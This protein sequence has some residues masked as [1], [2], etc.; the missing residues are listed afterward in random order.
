MVRPGPS[1]WLI[2]AALFAVYVIWGSTYVAMAVGVDHFPPFMLGGLR[3]TAAGLLIFAFI[4]WRGEALPT[5]A[6]W[7]SGLITGFF[8]LMIGNGAVNFAVM[9]V[10]SGLAAL[11]VA[12]SSLFAALF[13]RMLG[14]PVSRREWLGIAVGFAGVALLAS[15]GELR[16]DTFGALLLIVAS[17]SW[18][19]GSMWSKRLPQPP[20]VWMAS[21]T[22]LIC[23]GIGMLLVSLLRGEEFPAA[24]PPVAWFALVYLAIFGAIIAFS[25]YAFLLKHTRPAL[26]TSTAYVNPVIAVV[27]GGWLLDE[28]VT[29]R[30]WLAM[31]IVL[32]GVVLV[33]TGGSAR[34]GTQKPRA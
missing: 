30:E 33:T 24:P 2:A 1:P 14:D 17:A 9:T 8:L 6:Q 29:A 21:A 10:S 23:G 34:S 28:V 18:A 16:S 3:Y 22:Q 13:A 5:V 26:A 19:F 27:L 31:L 4:R 7:R 15:G 11:M 32:A 25:A 20:S 12:S